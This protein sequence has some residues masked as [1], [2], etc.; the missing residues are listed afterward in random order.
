MSFISV[1]LG[2]IISVFTGNRITAII[3]SI[4]VAVG[5]LVASFMGED[6]E[7]VVQLLVGGV[8]GKIS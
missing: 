6:D 5:F 1:L 4:L 2:A 8:G 7:I 3:G